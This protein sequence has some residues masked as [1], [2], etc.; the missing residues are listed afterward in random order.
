MDNKTTLGPVILPSNPD[1][2]EHCQTRFLNAAQNYFPLLVSLGLRVISSRLSYKE[3]TPYSKAK[4]SYCSLIIAE[5]SNP[6]NILLRKSLAIVGGEIK[7]IAI[8]TSTNGLQISQISDEGCSSKEYQTSC[9]RFVNLSYG[10]TNFNIKL[11]NGETVFDNVEFDEITPYKKIP[12]GN[13]QFEVYENSPI[14]PL[15]KANQPVLTF[16]VEIK[17][18]ET[19]T[20]YLV[21]QIYMTNGLQAVITY[22]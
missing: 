22:N 3:I 17:G 16:P 1:L 5:S 19:I 9:I 14:L 4:E 18:Y 7:T 10:G 13:Y 21:G 20:V 15:R 12:P 2:S 6:T 11:T 8:T